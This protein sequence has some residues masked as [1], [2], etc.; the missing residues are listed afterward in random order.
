LFTFQSVPEKEDNQKERMERGVRVLVSN[1]F[2]SDLVTIF[3]AIITILLFGCL[4]LVNR[5]ELLNTFPELNPI[6]FQ[7]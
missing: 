6:L 4:S 2:G 1:V 3:L 7:I 5:E